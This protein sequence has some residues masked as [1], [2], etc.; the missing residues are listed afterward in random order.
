MRIAVDAAD[1]GPGQRERGHARRVSTHLHRILMHVQVRNLNVNI[2]SH[3]KIK[4]T[5]QFRKRLEPG[6]SLFVFQ[7]CLQSTG[8]AEEVWE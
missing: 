1:S 2:C 3:K 6:T 4:T 5:L 7:S 8:H